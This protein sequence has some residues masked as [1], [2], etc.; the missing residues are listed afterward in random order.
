MAQPPSNGKHSRIPE[1]DGLR[2]LAILLV[3]SVHYFYNPDAN[4]PAVLHFL[5]GFFG[6]GWSGVDLF[7]VLSGFLIGGILLDARD[8]PNYFKTFY[9][10]RFF[11]I[12]PLYYLWFFC[13]VGLIFLAGSAFQ[14]LAPQPGF[15]WRLWG[16]LLFLQNMWMIHQPTLA[17]WWLGITWTLAIEEQFYLVAPLLVRQ[18]SRQHLIVFLSFVIL[19]VP[20]FRIL[21]RMEMHQPLLA[22][23]RWTPFRADTLAM[24]VL[25]AVLWRDPAFR[26]WLDRN[27]KIVYA[28]FGLL[29]AGMFALGIWFERP[30]AALT[31]TVG[32]SWIAVF[33][34]LLL[35]IPLADAAGPIARIARIGWLGEWGRV[36]YCMYLIHATVK[37]FCTNLI[38]HSPTQYTRWR[39]EAAIL[40]SLA[41]T[42][43]IAKLS[44][45]FFEGPLLREGHRY[46]Y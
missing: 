27:K 5:Q 25:A 34:A 35:L 33:Y 37:Y 41:V 43:G 20:C 19:T 2:G 14:A 23:Y 11:R 16:H 21:V 28:V 39:S 31:E 9:I 12:V 7:F 22:L 40:L 6:L 1:L 8:S 18:L 29:L 30:D 45:R 4:M 3:I 32:Y 38:V 42:F 24:G 10:R 15:N 44:W 13:L 36:S 26:A 46:K 17:T